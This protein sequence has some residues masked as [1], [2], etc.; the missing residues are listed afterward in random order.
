[1]VVHFPS[2]LNCLGLS[3][4]IYLRF[5]AVDIALKPNQSLNLYIYLNLIYSS[6]S[7]IGNTIGDSSEPSAQI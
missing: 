7:G 5:S 1:M 3:K 4:I 2:T 6:N